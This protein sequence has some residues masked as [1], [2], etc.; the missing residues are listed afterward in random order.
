M[1]FTAQKV[2]WCDR[3][4]EY[5]E[6]ARATPA[7][8]QQWRQEVADNQAQL[9][10]ITG[11]FESYVLTRVEEYATGALEMVIVAGAGEHAREVIRWATQLARENG[12]PS[13]RAHINRPGLQRIFEREG[14]HLAEWVM[15]IQNNGQ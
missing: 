7:D 14:Y 12:I 3:A 4:A 15:R 9:W 1:A 13:V 10:K 2:A 8:L 6:R 11:G 5:L